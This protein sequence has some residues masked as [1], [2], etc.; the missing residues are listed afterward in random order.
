MKDVKQLYGL[1]NE[2]ERDLLA[3]IMFKDLSAEKVYD[4][5]ND[6]NKDALYRMLWSDYVKMDVLAR[7]EERNIDLEDE[8]VNRITNMYVGYGEYDCNLSYWDNID[9]LIDQVC[10]E[11][12]RENL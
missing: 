4:R 10:M 5:L 2:Q 7:C 6:R 1:L 12:E 3:D 9:N 8:D 11:E